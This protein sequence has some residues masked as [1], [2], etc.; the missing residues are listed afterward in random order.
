MNIHAHAPAR[1]DAP[2][3]PALAAPELDPRG[4]PRGEVLARLHVPEV[5]QVPAAAAAA[6]EEEVARGA[7][8]V[9]GLF[10]GVPGDPE[11][12]DFES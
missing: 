9:G 6:L 1:C 7:P 10:P 11:I 4:Q 5:D 8:G 2:L 3:V 12:A